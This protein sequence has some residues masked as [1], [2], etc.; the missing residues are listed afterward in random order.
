MITPLITF[1][2]SAAG[3]SLLGFIDN[4]ITRKR[5]DNQR[6]EDRLHEERIASRNQFTEYAKAVEARSPGTLKRLSRK[7][8]LGKFTYENVKYKLYPTNVPTARARSIATGVLMLIAAYVTVMVLFAA[9]PSV[10]VHT[11][12]PAA[13]PSRFEFLLLFAYQFTTNNTYILTSGGV[14]YLMAH[15]L[16]FIISL[17]L[18]GTAR[19]I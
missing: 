5:E 19:R 18:T 2:G 6:A 11:I 16:I 7:F 15:P 13:E 8:T 10:I 4:I 12:N 9:F 3:G 14:A 17:I 1:L